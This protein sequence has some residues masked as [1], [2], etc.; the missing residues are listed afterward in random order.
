MASTMTATGTAATDA[1]AAA[2]SSGSDTAAIAASITAPSAFLMLL[3][4]RA[5]WEFGASFAAMPFVSGMPQGDGHPVLV[6]PGLA[7]DDVSTITLRNFLRARGYEPYPWNYGFNF[8][9][10]SGV[11]NGCIEHV[12]E[13]QQRHG[14]KVS[15]LG[16]SLGGIYAREIAKAVPKLTRGV[17]TLGT[18]FSGDPKATNA[19]RLYEL[20]SRQKVADTRSQAR[21]R[22]IAT[23][24]P[25]P[26]T[27]LYSKSDGIVAWQ[28]CLNPAGVPNMLVAGMMNALGLPVLS[29]ALIMTSS[30]ARRLAGPTAKARRALLSR[31]RDP[32]DVESRIDHAVAIWRVIGSPGYPVDDAALRERVGRGVRRSY[33][34]QG[35]MRQL[36]AA[37][38][39]GNRT[40]LLRDI[41]MPTMVLHG[42]LRKTLTDTRSRRHVGKA[43]KR[44]ALHSC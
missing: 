10:R 18:P 22:A 29:L 2:A 35:V 17:I 6:L 7:A 16:W 5:L 33:T 4:A 41:K 32:H 31:P 19:W 25:V 36:V 1:G 30:G 37:A 34:P 44:R 9:P 24:P 39:S 28:C 15:L 3:E 13:I 27:S 43:C 14:R 38:A 26:T 12:R 11:L 23:P 40:R 8:G 42:G 20:V 21:E